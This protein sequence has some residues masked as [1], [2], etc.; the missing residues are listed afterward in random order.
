MEDLEDH[1]FGFL[2]KLAAGNRKKILFLGATV[3]GVLLLIVIYTVSVNSPKTIAINVSVKDI[4]GGAF[5]DSCNPVNDAQSLNLDQLVVKLDGEAI[6]TTPKGISATSRGTGVCEISGE[7]SLMPNEEYSVEYSKNKLGKIKPKEVENGTEAFTYSLKFTKPLMVTVDLYAEYE[8]CTGTK[9]NYQCQYVGSRELQSCD[10]IGTDLVGCDYTNLY[11][12]NWP[13]YTEN[14]SDYCQGL[15]RLSF[16]NPDSPITITGLTNGQSQTMKLGNG[17]RNLV[18]VE[19][20]TLDCRMTVDF[21][22]FPYDEVGYRLDV[23]GDFQS[24]YYTNDLRSNG[25]IF[26]MWY[27]SKP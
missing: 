5:D 24:D 8:S 10:Y 9:D 27:G 12:S 2:P 6:S 20:R 7:Y 19:S 23:A 26:Q 15:N 16:I 4:Y 11:T 1:K 17:E 25:W 3:L 14:N 22:D 18:S 13:I 21:S